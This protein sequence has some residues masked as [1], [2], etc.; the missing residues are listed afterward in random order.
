MRLMAGCVCRVDTDPLPLPTALPSS[1][2]RAHIAS[3]TALILRLSWAEWR[4]HPWRQAAA[5]LAVALGV[6]LA[7]AVQL[8]NASALS[9]FETAVHA[10]SGAPDFSV[11]PRDGQ[12]PEALYPRVAMAAGV[13]QA[14]PVIDLTASLR[15]VDGQP[16]AARL[17]GLDAL[18]AP[19]ISPGWLVQPEASA[20]AST[21]AASGATASPAE[22]LSALDPD[23]VFANPAARALLGNADHV[24]LK[25]DGRWQTFALGGHIA[26]DGPAPARDGHR[27]RADAFRPRGHLVAHRRAARARRTP[28]R[29]DGRAGRRP[30]RARGGA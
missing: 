24:A 27:R 19:F 25:V 10:A 6:A 23:L 9:E 22:P 16:H 29:R 30:R 3:M 11:R 18:V 4:H 8:I 20:S 14:S 17:L 5:M 15:G 7:F 21:S 13:A 12:L 26:A 1:P 2:P 28:G